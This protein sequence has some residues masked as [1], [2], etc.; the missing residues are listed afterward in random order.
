MPSCRRTSLA[1]AVLTFVLAGPSMADDWPQFLGPGRNAVVPEA[2]ELVKEWSFEGPKVVWEIPVK[3]GFGG[4]AIYKDSVLL[5]DR[6]G[7]KGDV[8]KRVRLADGQEVW[9]FAYDAPGK[10]PVS[11]SR[12]TPAT[13]GKLVYTLGGFGHLYALDF[14][15]GRPKWKK[16]LIDDWGGKLPRW[17]VA[18]SPLLTSKYVIVSPWGRKAAVVAYSKTTGRVRWKTPNTLGAVLDYA[19]PVPMKLGKKST[20]VAMGKARGSSPVIG[21]D[22]RT[23]K[24]LWSYD[25]YRCSIQIPSPIV[26]DKGRIMLAGGYGAGS[27]MI[28]VRAKGRKYSVEQLWRNKQIGTTLAQAVPYKGYIYL[29]SGYKQKDFGLAC[30]TMAGEVKWDTDKDPNFDMGS[31]LLVGDVLFA[32]AGQNGQLVMVDPSPEGYKEIARANVLR[33]SRVW[34]P[35]AYSNGLLVIR[36]HSKMVCLDLR[37]K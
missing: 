16:H 31:I 14:K 1:I 28:Q 7:T 15:T 6:D 21:V 20:F 17:G 19:S 30:M 23:G 33:G 8:V 18:I 25:G 32:I 2:K 29:N 9:S 26:M 3:Q 34:A 37:K 12:S 22:A 4:A 10:L 24:L 36:D 35:M 11:G 5:I 13:D 27:A